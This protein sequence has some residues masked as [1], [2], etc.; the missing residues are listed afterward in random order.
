MRALSRSAAH[1]RVQTRPLHQQL[2]L[3]P[4]HLLKL[5]PRRGGLGV[6]L[7]QGHALGLRRSIQPRQLRPQRLFLRC[8]GLSPPPLQEEAALRAPVIVLRALRCA[9]FAAAI[10]CV[11]VSTNTASCPPTAWIS[12]L[13]ASIPN[14]KDF[15]CFCPIQP[16]LSRAPHVCAP[17]A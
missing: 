11:C 1:L 15:L 17:L 7:L 16:N 4:R 9:S 12:A 6:A 2:R 13:T 8:G 14:L 5:L 10:C 3:E